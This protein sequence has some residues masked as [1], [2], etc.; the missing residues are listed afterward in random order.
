M[1]LS[2]DFSL[3]QEDTMIFPVEHKNKKRLLVDEWC[4][5]MTTTVH[6]C[7][8][9]M[10]SGHIIAH[11][12]SCCSENYC[13]KCALIF[14][15]LVWLTEGHAACGC[16]DDNGE[17]KLHNVSMATVDHVW[18]HYYGTNKR[19]VWRHWVWCSLVMMGWFSFSFLF[20]PS[21]LL[22]ISEQILSK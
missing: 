20:F 3:G 15:A 9:V 22:W 19:I 17:P 8:P 7:G 1:L 12:L 5:Q 4:R 11:V 18:V 13:M 14:L 6:R 2:F 21:W 10:F 16:N